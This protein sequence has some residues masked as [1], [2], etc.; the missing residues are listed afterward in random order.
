MEKQLCVWIDSDL[1]DVLIKRAQH[2]RATLR[3]IV[4]GILQ[5]DVAREQSELLQRQ[6]FPVL[7]E[8]LEDEIRQSMAQLR[9][10]L[11]EDLHREIVEEMQ[12][13]VQTSENRLTQLTG[14][15][16]RDVTVLRRFL[17]A[18][19]TELVDSEFARNIYEEAREKAARELATRPSVKKAAAS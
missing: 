17:Y 1:K 14:R 8:L 3:D 2:E 16:V 7:H 19:A 9:M 10:H 4:E 6:A 5:Q 15:V 18:L 12:R 11:R 13:L